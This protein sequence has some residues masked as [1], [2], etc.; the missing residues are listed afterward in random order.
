MAK[1]APRSASLWSRATRTGKPAM[2]GIDL[3]IHSTASDGLLSPS[4]VV[5]VALSLG[6]THIALCDHDSVDGVSEAIDAARN[7][8]LVVVPGV[9]LSAGTRDEGVHILGYFI[10]HDD[11]QLRTR[12]SSLRDIRAERARKLIALL[13][14][15]GISIGF[16]E[17]LDQAAGGSVGRAHVAHLLVRRGYA[18]SVRDAF[19][20]MLGEGRP[21][22]V[23]K[24]VH[25]PADVIG[26]VRDAGGVAVL[27]HPALSRADGLVGDLKA[28]GLV[29]IEAYH[30][31]HDDTLRDHYARMAGRHGLI[32]TGG[33]D[34]H[35]EGAGGH[36]I[37]SAHVPPHVYDDLVAAS[38]RA[39]A[40]TDR[41]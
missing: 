29:G 5:R 30:G 15:G 8:T 6:L 10:D 35:G 19:D 20:R 32:V 31:D 11:A 13:E 41:A 27:A 39:S 14:G 37:G 38:V 3:H 18:T 9:E 4:E 26:W 28:A 22:Y 16:E 1:N 36:P 21:F 12:L 33:S 23:P 40:G 17:V 2:P 25:S 7:T 24:P 34:F